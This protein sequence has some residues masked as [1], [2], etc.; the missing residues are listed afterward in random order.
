MSASLV[1]VEEVTGPNTD[2]ARAQ[3]FDKDMNGHL[4]P[5]VLMPVFGYLSADAAK[6]QLSA[7]GAPPLAHAAVSMGSD[8]NGR[9]ETHVFVGGARHMWATM[10][11]IVLR[12][13]WRVWRPASQY[14]AVL[15]GMEALP[16]Y[17]PL[18]AD[19]LSFRPTLL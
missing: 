11:A 10:S 17:S 18:F 6:A 4:H 1:I 2:I 15:I 13:K 7:A 19:L 3:A 9:L 14:A 8:E 12:Q 16:A 5:G